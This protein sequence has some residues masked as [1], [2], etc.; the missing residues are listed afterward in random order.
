MTIDDHDVAPH[1]L[2]WLWLVGA[3]IGVFA[4]GVAASALNAALPTIVREFALPFWQLRWITAGPALTFAVLVVPAAV[5]GRLLGPV[6]LYLFGA[7]VLVIAGLLGATAHS[8]AVLELAR[9]GEGV[10][11]AFLV[12]Q[13]VVYALA[14]LGRVERALVCG[15]FAVAFVGGSAVGPL[16]V[17]TLVTHTS[18]RSVLWLVVALAVVA[19]LAGAP[20]VAQRLPIRLDLRSLLVAVIALPAFAAIM[21]PL[22]ARDVSDWTL[23]SYASVSVGIVLFA[24]CLVIEATRR[25]ARA[26]IAAPILAVVAL[27]GSTHLTLLFVY[28]QAV[29]GHSPQTV[30]YLGLLGAV[31]ALLSAALAMVLGFWLDDRF[32]AIGGVAFIGLAALAVGSAAGAALASALAGD[33]TGGN[34]ADVLRHAATRVLVGSLVLLVVASLPAIALD[35]RLPDWSGRSAGRPAAR[36]VREAA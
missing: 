21:L 6:R 11:A 13:P 7:L 14:Y 30:S 1:P 36:G 15:L 8:A 19:G 5:L 20:L 3:A 28:L 22:V 16:V 23:W 10:G 27:A 35:R 33:T 24:V 4:V 9:L 12:P 31:G 29:A 34:P 25:G 2:R 17:S 26:G 18:W 32:A